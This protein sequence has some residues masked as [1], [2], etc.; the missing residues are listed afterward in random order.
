MALCVSWL[1]FV[2]LHRSLSGRYYWWGPFDLLPP[3]VFAAVPLLLLPVAQFARPVRWR[4]TLV[5]VLALVLGL[6]ISGINFGTV[7]YSPSAPPPDAIKL[8]TWNTEYWDQDVR[9]SGHGTAYFY[10]FLRGLDADVYLLH[11]YAH[12]DF[13]LPDVFAQALVIDQMAELRQNFPGYQIILEGRNITLSRLPVVA[14]RP[15]YS[16]PWLPDDLKPLPPAFDGHPL[17]YTSQVLRT[18]IRVGD[19]VV[20]FYD[21]HLF[22]PPRRMLMMKGEPGQSVFQV[23]RFNFSMRRASLEAIRA[24]VKDN[25][26]PIVLAG[27][28]NTSPSMGA[29]RMLPDRLVDHT[30]ALSSL[31]PATWEVGKRPYWRIDW[32]RT[33]PDV[34]V[35]RY[36]FLDPQGLSDHRVQQIQLTVQG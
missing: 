14:H 20:S 13:T 16:T 1:V 17:F 23:D 19:R 26:Q 4:L 27:D 11:E 28:L 15:L 18:D 6:G 12:A 10:R 35:H 33:T 8:V 30:R 9:E 22:Q 7:F 36:E 31:Y 24:D 32:L 2:V 21:T 5:P 25:P 3:F 34:N 29:L